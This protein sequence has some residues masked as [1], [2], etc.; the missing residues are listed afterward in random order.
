LILG[1][2][3]VIAGL[4]VLV[5]GTALDASAQPGLVAGSLC[6]TSGPIAGLS[7]DAAQ[8]AR[9]VVAVASARA[10]ECGS[11]VALMVGITESGLRILGNPSDPTGVTPVEG[12]GFDHDSLGIFQ[13][14]PSWGSAQQRLDPTASTNLFIDRLLQRP[15]WQTE[16]WAVAQD[17]QV[18]AWDGKPRAANY[19]SSTYGGNYKTELAE[20]TRIL[21]V[22]QI[23]S[24]KKAC[25]GTV[26]R[27]LARRRL[28]RPMA[29]G[30]RPAT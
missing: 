27:T 9:T 13:Q 25:A 28:G 20:A 4:L 30:C 6:A 2:I 5:G 8:D 21:Q 26:D 24:A 11:V 19:F 18:S 12:V 3:V 16:P 7:A 23:D 10:G 15:G 14:R 22:I 17:V 29:T 1:P